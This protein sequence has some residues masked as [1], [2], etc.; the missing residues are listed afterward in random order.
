MLV[1]TSCKENRKQSK[2]EVHSNLGACR[3]LEVA[4]A[5]APK[6]DEVI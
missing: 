6:S 2:N 4:E 3:S 1:G 5:L